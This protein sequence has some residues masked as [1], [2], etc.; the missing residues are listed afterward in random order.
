MKTTRHAHRAAA[1]GT[2]TLALALTGCTVTGEGPQATTATPEAAPTTQDPQAR[3]DAV[4]DEVLDLYQRET[5]LRYGAEDEM[6]GEEAREVATYSWIDDRNAATQQLLGGGRELDRLEA[7][8]VG[9]QV[10]G[11]GIV[12]DT[13]TLN[14][15]V[16]TR[17]DYRE[18][19]GTVI[20][21][22][23]D[24]VGGAEQITAM[25]DGPED[26][27]LTS[28]ENGDTAPCDDED[29][30]GDDESSET[31]EAP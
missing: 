19:D 27:K 18:A 29:A 26:W 1:A 20:D 6:L 10:V 23:D 30:S 13:L 3:L 9:H 22:P 31:T 11:E 28:Y 17:W 14:V 16:E 12:D 25:T 4:T 15:C 7:T 8:I 2:V 5:E 24:V 21:D